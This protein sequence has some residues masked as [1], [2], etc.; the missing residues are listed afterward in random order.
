MRTIAYWLSLVLIFMIPWENVNSLG[1]TEATWARAVGLLVGAFWVFTVIVTGE[2]RN[3]H[4]FHLAVYLFLLWNVIS[5][6]WSVDVDRTVDRIQTYLQL[7]VLVFILWDLYTTPAALK[8]GLQAYVL[9]AYVAIGSTV[10][11]YLAGAQ[12]SYLRY[13]ATGFNA[14]DLGLTLAL[15]IPVAWYLALSECDSKKDQ[16]LRLVNYAYLPAATLAILLTASRGSLVA[17]IPG[18]FYV[19]ASLPRLKLLPRVFVFVAL[20]GALFAL[21]PLV[22]QATLQRLATTGTQIAEADLGGRVDI[23][24]QGLAVFSEHPLFGIGSGAFR[25]AV[26]SGKTPHNSFISVLVDVGM[27]GL[28][29]FVVILAMAVSPIM[30]QP[31]WISRF[32]LSVLL[33]LALGNFVHNW[34]AEKPTWLFLGLVIV[35][36]SQS[37]QRDESL[38]VSEFPGKLKVIVKG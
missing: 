36:A 16:L 14:N 35:S 27:I 3:P 1:S 38:P 5:A 25:A 32:W 19:I 18:Y 33:V 10:A 22:P 23:W 4:P 24:A 30:R 17:A 21:Q 11:N 31:K 12:E 13:S 6:F 29:L 15:G 37:V 7:A 9:G 34:E 28:V 8:A 26:K 2:F 20:V